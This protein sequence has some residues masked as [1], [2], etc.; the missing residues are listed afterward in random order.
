MAGGRG[1]ELEEALL[2]YV[3]NPAAATMDEQNL[4]LVHDIQKA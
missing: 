2:E 1:V 4:P 3:Y